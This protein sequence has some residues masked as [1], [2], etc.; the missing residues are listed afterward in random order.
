MENNNIALITKQL[1]IPE[2]EPE[3]IKKL[4]YTIRG[5]QIM[6]DKDIGLLYNYEA[7]EINKEMNK[8]KERFPED[9]CFKI[10]SEEMKNI[11]IY[12][13]KAKEDKCTNYA[14]TE[15]GIAMLAGILKGEKVVQTSVTILQTFAEMRKFKF[16]KDSYYKI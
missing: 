5:K 7:T 12:L 14:Y 2:C 10:T 13:P 16:Q 6:L 3:N 9:F 4:I 15:Y 8:N 11:L 1:K